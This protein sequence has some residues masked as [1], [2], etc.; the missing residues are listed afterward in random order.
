MNIERVSQYVQGKVSHLGTPLTGEKCVSERALLARFNRILDD[1]GESIRKCRKNSR[2][3]R[4][5]G[6]YYCINDRTKRVTATHIDLDEYS[7][8]WFVL[9]DDEV[10]TK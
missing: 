9:E 1:E 2:L 7:R 3:Y 10:I 6:D 4:A 8:S 5:L